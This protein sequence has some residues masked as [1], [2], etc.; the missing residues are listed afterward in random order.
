[1]KTIVYQVLSDRLGYTGTLLQR[2]FEYDIGVT[3]NHKSKKYRQNNDP[4]KKEKKTNNDLQN[5]TQEN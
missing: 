5:V 2:T 3:R 1:M 4:Q